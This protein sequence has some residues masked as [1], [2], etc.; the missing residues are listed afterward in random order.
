MIAVGVV[1]VAIA[2]VL[3]LSRI[4]AISS[5]TLGPVTLVGVD[6]PDASGTA[7]QTLMKA[8]PDTVNDLSRRETVGDATASRAWGD[9]AV[10]LRCGVAPPDDLDCTVAITNVNNVWW[11]QQS[12]TDS[13]TYLSVD[14]S[15]HIA[16][17]MPVG[18]GTGPLQQLSD[19]IA[20]TLPHQGYCKTP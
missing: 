15:V 19:V 18:S 6:Q 11:Y 13:T 14:R 12:D 9:P 3:V 8:L 20:T 7:C 16:V 17:T 2:A 4:A 10:I 1:L 5:A